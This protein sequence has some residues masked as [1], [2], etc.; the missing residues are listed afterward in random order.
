MRRTIVYGLSVAA[1]L[2]GALVVGGCAGEQTADDGSTLTGGSFGLM[3]VAYELDGAAGPVSE[4]DQLQLNTHAQFVR[5]TAMDRQHVARLLGLPLD[6]ERD[7][8]PLDTCR[9]YDLTLD[10]DEDMGVDDALQ[11]EEPSHVELLEA[12]D[13]Q[14][15][16]PSRT[17]TLVPRHFPGLLPFISGVIYGE[18][19]A[20]EDEQLGHVEVESAGGETVGAFSVKAQTPA[21]PRLLGVADGMAVTVAERAGL[22]LHWQTAAPPALTYIDVRFDRAKRELALRCRPRDDGAFVIPAALLAEVAESAKSPVTLEIA[23]VQGTS[24][25]ASGLDGGE[26]RITV[27]ERAPIHFR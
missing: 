26:L 19:Q 23:R 9:I 7:L 25:T 8:P 1:L 12:G 27:R 11:Q 21:L 6:P 5:Y 4:G 13:L 24:F 17:V 15:Q 20:T 16:T 10:L 2:A 22:P 14:V 3:S 18:A